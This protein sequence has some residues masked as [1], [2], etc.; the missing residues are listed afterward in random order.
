ME[1][2]QVQDFA[3]TQREKFVSTEAGAGNS[4]PPQMPTDTR[5]GFPNP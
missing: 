5:E 2:A 1:N 4:L 3:P